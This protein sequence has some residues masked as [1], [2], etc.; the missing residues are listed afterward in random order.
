MR[1]YIK[2]HLK[3]KNQVFQTT[4]ACCA[5]A[6]RTEVGNSTHTSFLV[7]SC[8]PSFTTKTLLDGSGHIA[9]PLLMSF[10]FLFLSS[11]ISAMPRRRLYGV[12]AAV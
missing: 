12:E 10:A 1:T 5:A 7:L 3:K 2:V 8:K 6:V 9:I 11:S 4:D